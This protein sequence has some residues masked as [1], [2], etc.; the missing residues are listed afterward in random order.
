MSESESEYVLGTHA[1]EHARLGYQHRVWAGPTA[2]AWERGGFRPGS[3][4]LD[5]GCGPGYATFNLAQLV[6]K[7]GSVVAVDMSERFVGQ[8]E[9]ERKR[10]GLPNIEPRVHDLEA[11]D[12]PA[13][14]VDFAF[15]RW[16]LCFV[17]QPQLV[18]ERVARTLRPGGTFVVMDYVNYEGFFVAPRSE[19]IERGIAAVASSF[20]RHGGDPNV[21][22]ELP[23]YMQRAGLEVRSI[24]PIVRL[25]RPGSALWEWPWTFFENF[26]PTLVDSGALAPD[27]HQAFVRDWQARTRDPAAFLMTPP[28]VEVIG[29]KAAR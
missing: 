20:R 12:E 14:S 27:E 19:A 1:A 10:R 17:G 2:D 4:I 15:A 23:G 8:L 9:A 26:L 28:M 13:S 25:A 6:G 18:V 11:L 3:R 29:A 24:R 5:V 16:V 21:G 7:D 22:R